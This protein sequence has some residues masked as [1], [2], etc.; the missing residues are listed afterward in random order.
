M[1]KRTGETPIVY[2]M[3]YHF[4]TKNGTFVTK[5]DHFVDFAILE[6]AEIV[7]KFYFCFFIISV[8]IDYLNI[9]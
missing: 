7:C 5:N 2:Y 8:S 6:L 1:E 3:F 9:N 4:V